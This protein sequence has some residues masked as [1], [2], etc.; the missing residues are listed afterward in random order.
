MRMNRKIQTKHF[1]YMAAVPKEDISK[2]TNQEH[3]IKS[4]LR[5][6]SNRNGHGVN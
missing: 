1:V 2:V 4:D 3:K 6:D 5:S